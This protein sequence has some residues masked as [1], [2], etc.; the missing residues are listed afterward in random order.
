MKWV[1]S[2]QDSQMIPPDAV[3]AG[4]DKYGDIMYAGKADYNG[5]SLACKIVPS[6]EIFS[7]SYCGKEYRVRNFYYLTGSGFS[8]VDGNY[9]NVPSNAVSTG[10][11]SD[12]ESLYIGRVSISN[13]LTVGK[14][15]P[16]Q[17]CL[18]VPFDWGEHRFSHYEVLIEK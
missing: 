3:K 16:S 10:K 2:S 18:F 17:K 9:G 5:D 15:H 6:R 13:T 8:W 12:G 7:V 1:R 11:T 14:I 4:Y